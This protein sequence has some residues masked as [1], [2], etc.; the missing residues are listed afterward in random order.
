MQE[1]GN[2]QSVF[3]HARTNHL[4]NEKDCY[5]Y[6]SDNT[7]PKSAKSCEKDIKYTKDNREIKSSS[8]NKSLKMHFNWNQTEI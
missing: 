8:D 5:N 7:F 4:Q 3:E 2:P 1:T 6:R